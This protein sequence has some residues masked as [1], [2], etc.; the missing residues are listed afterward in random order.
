MQQPVCVCTY[1]CACMF[2][3]MHACVCVCACVHT[4]CLYMYVYVHCMYVSVFLHVCVHSACV[5]SPET[6]EKLSAVRNAKHSLLSPLTS[7]CIPLCPPASK[8]SRTPLLHPSYTPPD[9]H[10]SSPGPPWSSCQEVNRWDVGGGGAAWPSM[11]SPPFNP[12]AAL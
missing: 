12:S 1:V 3:S 6:V 9:L 2:V 5:C 4:V 8:S 10:T 7:H 11:C